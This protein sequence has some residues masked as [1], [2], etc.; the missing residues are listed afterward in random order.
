M[1]CKEG[2]FTHGIQSAQVV[3]PARLMKRQAMTPKELQTNP[4]YPWLARR[5]SVTA[6]IA[7]FFLLLSGA[8]LFLCYNTY[9][10]TVQKSLIEDRA[11]ADLCALIIEEHFQKI[12]KTLES[13][14]NRRLLSQAVSQKNIHEAQRHLKNLTGHNPDMESLIITDSTG[15]LWVSEPAR[16]DVMEK[17]FA[18]RE[19]YRGV[20]ENWQ[21]YI[22]DAVLRITGD[23]GTAIQIA[24]PIVDQKDNVVGILLNTQ[25]AVQL[26]NIIRKANL[27]AGVTISV[28]DRQSRIIC[29]SRYAYEKKIALYPFADKLREAMTNPDPSRVFAEPQ[30]GGIER[31]L[32]PVGVAGIGWTV[33]VERD[34]R[35]IL[36]ETTNDFLQYI[37]IFILF[38]STITLLLLFFQKHTV[39]QIELNNLRNE[40]ELLISETR[41]RELFDHMSGGVA[42]YDVVHDGEDFIFSDMNMAGRRITGVAEGY[43]GK[44]VREVFPGVEQLGLFQVFRQVWRTG[45]AMSLPH[46]M[47]QDNNLAFWTENYVFKLP[48][49]QIVAMFDDVTENKRA[50]EALKESEKRLREAQ[51]MAHLGFWSWDVKTGHVEWSNEVFNIF[52]LNPKEFKPQIDSILALSPWPEDH[53]RDREL[54]SRAMANH[55]PGSYEQKFLRP[56]Q[57]VGYY[58]STFR[59]NYN[60]KGELTSIVG[61]V[62]DITERKQTEER[63]NKL[64]AELE[65]KVTERTA[66]L[67]AKNAELE[68]LN[69][70]FV[71]REL[72]MRELKARISELEKK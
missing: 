13:Y 1:S 24:M 30:P 59:G 39:T 19:W 42:I 7:V 62:L 32:S 60:E 55:N 43:S 51:E 5:K 28:I 21:P 50:E 14:A 53:Q 47:Y 68:R 63:I 69:Q 65:Q 23:R 72:R 4:P 46:S 17:T 66:E 36:A 22:T 61:T 41:F 57:S 31:Y 35:S 26:G 15:M 33:V 45:V 2:A 3:S 34:R 44:S 11:S 18:Y 9:Q 37:V 58:Y 27:A 54:I 25:R 49:G 64:N 16:P 29:S 48:S 56:D 6:L 52:G 38:F 8:C 67:A 40:K 10:E 71:D 20:S 12:V 70:V